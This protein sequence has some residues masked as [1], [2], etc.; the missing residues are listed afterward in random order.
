MRLSANNYEAAQQVLAYYEDIKNARSASFNRMSTAKDF[1]NGDIAIPLPEL[2]RHE[3]PAVAN[4]MTLLNRRRPRHLTAYGMT[5][6]SVLPVSD[7]P[8]E[9]RCS[10][11]WRVRNPLDTFPAPMTNPD[12][13]EPTFCIFRDRK[14]ASWLNQR[15]PDAFMAV[16]RGKDIDTSSIEVLE[17]LDMYETVLVA[18]GQERP[19]TDIYGRDIGGGQRT[20][21]ILARVPNRIGIVPVVIAGRI[22]L[23]RLQGQFDQTFGM[24]MREA[25]L[26]ALNT[27][28]IS[29]NVFRDEWAVSSSN[30]PSSPR[31][32]KRANGRLGEIGII[33]KGQLQFSGPPMNQE[34]LAAMDRYERNVRVTGTVLP[35]YGGESGS[36][37]RTA[38]RA[39]EVSSAAVDMAL[40]EA[41]ELLAASAEIEVRIA[42]NEVKEYYGDRPS[43]FVFGKNGVVTHKDY[44]PNETFNI[45]LAA[46]AYPMPGTD[47][48]SLTVQAGQLKGIGELSLRT[49]REL[50]PRIDDPEE[51][52][53]RVAVENVEQAFMTGI[54]QGAAQQSI[55]PIVL[56]KALQKMRVGTD[57]IDAFV[58]VHEEMQAQQQANQEQMAQSQGATTP[59]QQ[60]GATASPANPPSAAAA[61]G[62]A[63]ATPSLQDLLAR[64]GGPPNAQK[65]AVSEQPAPAP[66]G[67]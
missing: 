38:R 44:V 30:S 54:E 32:I 49:M 22:T 18:V 55:D 26:D 4:H 9:K 57:A 67:V 16:S 35:E 37:M 51:E 62:G 46:V 27:I 20:A 64:L 2:D 39:A 14:T 23:D 36:N 56:A 61:P 10:P 29:R 11:H 7:D 40:Q 33:D 47:L 31:I 59:E 5:V 42:I 13:M 3:R 41:Q 63:G 1:Y 60:P 12:S 19:Q 48:A 25:K 6:V 34:I 53:K 15:Y 8:N 58:A 50:D 45:D 24:Y 21:H 43:M 28:A 17:F 65:N 52:A 66:V